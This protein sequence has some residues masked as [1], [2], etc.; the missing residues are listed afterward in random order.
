MPPKTEDWVT[1]GGHGLHLFSLVKTEKGI[2]ESGC[3]LNIYITLSS[4]DSQAS[5]LVEKTTWCQDAFFGSGWNAYYLLVI[6]F[7]GCTTGGVYVPCIQMHAR[8]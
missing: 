8:C 4:V 1:E 2:T 7:W 5:G 6:W 3:T